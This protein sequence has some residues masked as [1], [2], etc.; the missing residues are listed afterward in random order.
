MLGS[1]SPS[2][3]GGVSLEYRVVKEDRLERIKTAKRRRA[4]P[5]N[6]DTRRRTRR[7]AL[8]SCKFINIRIRAARR[9]VASREQFRNKGE[10][11]RRGR[12]RK[13]SEGGG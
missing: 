13:R 9:R 3:K 11:R 6:E 4:L 8:A 7:H 1:I 10:E 12:K 2:W 5:L